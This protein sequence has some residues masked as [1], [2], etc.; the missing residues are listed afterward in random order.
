M[1]KTLKLLNMSLIALGITVGLGVIL[2]DRSF[3]IEKILDKITVEVA[4]WTVTPFIVLSIVAWFSSSGAISTPLPAVL[5][6]AVTLIIVG[7]G[8]FE[9]LNSFVI[10]LDPQSGLILLF[11]PRVQLLWAVILG[12]LCAI[13]KIAANKGVLANVFRGAR[14]TS[15]NA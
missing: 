14:K 2:W 10:N 3:S 6:L 5:S 12:I 8:F 1:I 13:V 7:F 11:L 4:L 15:P 9:L